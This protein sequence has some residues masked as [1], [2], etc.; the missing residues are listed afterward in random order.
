MAPCFNFSMC[1]SV[2]PFWRA[3]ADHTKSRWSPPPPRR[4][5]APS[6]SLLSSRS[7]ARPMSPVLPPWRER[8]SWRRTP[9]RGQARDGERGPARKMSTGKRGTASAGQKENEHGVIT[10]AAKL[11][12]KLCVTDYSLW[13]KK[14]V[15][16]QF[17]TVATSH[18]C[19]R[20][21][22]QPQC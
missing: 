21:K 20:R 13:Q 18:S 4:I 17:F 16:P 11:G 10:T 8:P 5:P 6:P 3:A 15:V 1:P 12:T 19:K 22:Q 2:L 14:K 7:P 9:R